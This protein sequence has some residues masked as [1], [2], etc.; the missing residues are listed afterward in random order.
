MRALVLNL[1]GASERM[2]FQQ[3]QL[4]RLGISFERVEAVTPATLEPPA[5]D[6]WWERW[7]R[8]MRDA[9]KAILASHRAAWARIAALGAP[10]LV[11]E[12]DAWLGDGVPALLAELEPLAGIDH[13]TLET[14]GRR[15]LV[16]RRRLDCPAIQR[17]WQ[18]RTG[19][20]AY[21]LWPAGAR[22]L[23][24]R[25]AA[26]PGLADAVICSAYELS[27]WQAVPALAI[28]I[29]QAATYGLEPP[30]VTRSSV[31]PQ[32]RSKGGVAFRLRRLWAQVRMGLRALS[33]LPVAKRVLLAPEGLPQ[34]S[35]IRS[36][37]SP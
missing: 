20:A 27:S 11:L 9:E 1:A 22:K 26:R 24:A 14:R 34:S 23:L 8:P 30:M 32:A 3:G 18:D 37:S 31:L 33:V 12:D 16:G 21:V 35:P 15:K 2:A 13:V 10:A 28:Q 4:D 36:S 17:L 6:P 25:S 5:G 19:A 7:E 29:D